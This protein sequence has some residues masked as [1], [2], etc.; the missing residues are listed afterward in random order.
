METTGR[1]KWRRDT[2]E[3]D[4]AVSFYVPDGAGPA[5]MPSETPKRAAM[6]PEIAKAIVEVMGQ[7]KTLGKE[8]ENKFQK[9]NY[10]SVNQFYEAVGPLMAKAG[11]FT[12]PFEASMVVDKRETTDD[13]GKTKVSVWLLATYDI[14][15]YHA[16][17]AQFGPIPRSIQVPANGAQAYA[18]AQSFIGKYLLRDLFKVPTGDEEGVDDEPKRP[19]PASTDRDVHDDSRNAADAARAYVDRAK[20]EFAKMTTAAEMATWWDAHRES[21]GDFFLGNSDPLWIEMKTAFTGRSRDINAP[22]D[23]APIGAPKPPPRPTY[24]ELTDSFY[25]ALQD[26]KTADEAQA[27]YAK[28]VEPFEATFTANQLGGLKAMIDDRVAVL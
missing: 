10:T 4:D 11:I 9:Y 1:D 19:L 3:G 25:R 13:Y 23:A 15:I 20:R 18:S 27:V 17:G 28:M 16:S 24:K 5:P 7:I 26:V 21:F 8:G 14:Y 2:P 22:D 12:L 6:P